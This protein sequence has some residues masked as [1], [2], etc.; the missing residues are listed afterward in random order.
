MIRLLGFL[1]AAVAGGAGTLLAYQYWFLGK[2]SNE[3][4]FGLFTAL[5]VSL[6][7][8][9]GMLAVEQAERRASEKQHAPFITRQILDTIFDLGV[10]HAVL[11]E[12]QS[13]GK[14]HLDPNDPFIAGMREQLNRRKDET[15][16]TAETKGM[17]IPRTLNDLLALDLE[18]GTITS[19]LGKE[20]PVG[21]VL[22]RIDRAGDRIGR[23]DKLLSG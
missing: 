11:K 18:I 13:S 6:V 3:A 23:L 2:V 20:T 5:L 19:A 10:V 22:E 8:M 21:E 17:Q 16:A 14:T 15:R 1:L 4:V 12:S 7:G 9:F